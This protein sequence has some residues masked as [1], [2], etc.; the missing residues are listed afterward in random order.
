[1]KSPK[2][3]IN[4]ECVKIIP[5]VEL[6]NDTISMISPKEWIN[7]ECVQS[8]ELLDDSISMKSPKEWINA[9]FVKIIPYVELIDDTFDYE[10]EK[11]IEVKSLYANLIQFASKNILLNIF[12]SKLYE[13]NCDRFISSPFELS[14]L[15]GIFKIMIIP[16]NEKQFKMKTKNTSGIVT[17]KLLFI[18]TITK[19]LSLIINFQIYIGNKFISI[20]HNFFGKN[21]INIDD[22]ITIFKLV[23]ESNEINIKIFAT[24]LNASI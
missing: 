18:E 3:W 11:I 15:N 7:G 4:G 24:V 17:I 9:E 16:K 20:T 14:N 19:Y 12:F 22:N 2:E 23:N 21:Y 6:I 8:K 13:K 1:M 5:S 10:C